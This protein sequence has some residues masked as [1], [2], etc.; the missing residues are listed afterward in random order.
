MLLFKKKTK[1]KYFSSYSNIFFVFNRMIHFLLFLSKAGITF[2]T[3][4]FSFAWSFSFQIPFKRTDCKTKNSGKTTRRKRKRER[5]KSSVGGDKSSSWKTPKRSKRYPRQ[6]GWMR[7]AVVFE[8][9]GRQWLI[10]NV[11][12]VQS[13]ARRRSSGHPKVLA[14]TTVCK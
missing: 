3:A 9:A 12:L 14:A 7:L 8:P 11:D 4:W 10:S 5:R 13:A 2:V 6:S 1:T